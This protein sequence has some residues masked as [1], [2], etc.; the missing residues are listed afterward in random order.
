MHPAT[1]DPEEFFNVMSQVTP[2]RVDLVR[3]L[4]FRSGL[5]GFY[6]LFSFQTQLLHIFNLLLLE[7]CRKCSGI[8]S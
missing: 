1:F 7:W 3:G 5:N 4:H 2:E 8:G 6:R